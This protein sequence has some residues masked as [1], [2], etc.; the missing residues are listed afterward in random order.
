MSSGD[1]HS[2]I[3]NNR[4]KI[5]QNEKSEDSKQI[6]ASNNLHEIGSERSNSRL[7][8]SERENKLNDDKTND[9]F[10]WLEKK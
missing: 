3:Q 6:L 4:V 10:E 8:A 9:K 1:F 2:I 7:T 5:N